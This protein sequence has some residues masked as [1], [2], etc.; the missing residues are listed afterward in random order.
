MPERSRRIIDSAIQLANEGGF[1]A[2][3]LRDVAAHSGV[4]LGTL[5]TRFR[6]KED[7]LVAALE[8]EMA[9]LDEMVEVQP[10][11]G[12]TPEARVTAF[13]TIASRVL[14]TR[15][16]FARAVLRSVASGEPETAEKVLA[17][18][19]RMSTLV[20]RS[21]LGGGEPA[22][23]SDVAAG[24]R[25]SFMLQ[26]IWFANL[27]GWMGGLQDEEEVIARVDEAVRLLSGHMLSPA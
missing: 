11:P 6:S 24:E 19:S 12:V 14:F 9:K 16:H 25:L 22:P 13:F 20:M 4:A 7:I 27:V 1:Q 2:V 21:M 10:P 5:Y 8:E 26:Q 18:H 15:Q 23:G 17:F 3:R